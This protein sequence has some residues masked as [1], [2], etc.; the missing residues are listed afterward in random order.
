VQTRISSLLE[1]PSHDHMLEGSNAVANGVSG[2][3]STFGVISGGV[4]GSASIMVPFAVSAVETAGSNAAHENLQ[5]FYV[6]HVI[7][8]CSETCTA[9][10]NNTQCGCDL[11]TGYCSIQTLPSVPLIVSGPTVIP[12]NLTLPSTSSIVV[13]AS[14]GGVIVVNGTAVLGGTLTVVVSS[15]QS[16]TV[17]TATNIAGTFSTVNVVP[18]YQNCGGVQGT[19]SYTSSTVS[20]TIQDPGCSGL[21]T[22][23][24]IGIVVGILGAAILAAIIGVLFHRHR[25]DAEMH[26]AKSKISLSQN[27]TAS[28]ASRAINL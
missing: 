21:S 16:A 19:A 10:L 2:P 9:T 12:N 5:P 22:G 8:F 14:S 18:N 23:A 28:Q 17:L 4:Y 3:S 24:I 25:N 1:L 27:S 20:V 26:R 15:S 11:M 13:N 7:L 6:M